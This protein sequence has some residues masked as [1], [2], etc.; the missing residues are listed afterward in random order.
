MYL[1]YNERTKQQL[2]DEGGEP[3]E[4]HYLHTAQE[5]FGKHCSNML[6][7]VI[8]PDNCECTEPLV[9]FD[10]NTDYCKRCDKLVIKETT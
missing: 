5:Y 6:D 1:I 10:F 8:K 7:V 4:F 3:I 9:Q 2:T